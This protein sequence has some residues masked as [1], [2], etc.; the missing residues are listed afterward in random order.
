MNIIIDNLKESAIQIYDI[1]KK[2]DPNVISKSSN[3]IN[4]SGDNV[5]TIDLV[6]NDILCEG[7]KNCN[8]IKEI[9]SEEE[10]DIIKVN[11]NGEYLVSLDPLDGSQNIEV[12]ITCG[13]IFGIYGNYPIKNGRNIICSGYF[14]FSSSLQLIIT[15]QEQPVQLFTY[16]NEKWR[17]DKNLIIPDKNKIYSITPTGI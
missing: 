11:N 5:Q 12:N 9:V 4:S 8:N 17:F 14:L 7:L 15:Y 16:Y 13:I 10:E 2:A 3:T 6:A 1:L